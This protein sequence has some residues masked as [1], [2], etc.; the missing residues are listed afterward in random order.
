MSGGRIF[1]CIREDILILLGFLFSLLLLSLYTILLYP[2]CWWER[3]K[4]GKSKPQRGQRKTWLC[5][6]VLFLILNIHNQYLR[7]YILERI[8]WMVWIL[9]HFAVPLLITPTCATQWPILTSCQHI[10]ARF[11]S[12]SLTLAAESWWPWQLDAAA[13][14]R[15][16]SSLQ[17]HSLLVCIHVTGNFRQTHVT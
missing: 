15:G 8:L 11:I 1:P 6:I 16:Q 3:S 5:Q 2:A 7:N 12:T 4:V 17:V 10:T 9:G 13:W 14:K